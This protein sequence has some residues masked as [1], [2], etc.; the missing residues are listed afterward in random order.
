MER[1]GESEASPLPIAARFSAAL[2]DSFPRSGSNGC[3]CGLLPIYHTCT[4]CTACTGRQREIFTD[5]P[6]DRTTI[7]PR[8]P[9][10]P[11]FAV[12]TGRAPLVALR[13]KNMCISIGE[14]GGRGSRARLNQRLDISDG[15]SCANCYVNACALSLSL[16]LFLS[17]CCRHT[18]INRTRINRGNGGTFRYVTRSQSCRSR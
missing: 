8:P 4:G 17:A 3:Y 16:S 13:C 1:N 2:E 18:W 9:P 12:V 11:G 15:R 7:G 6:R 5:S 14:G 10:S